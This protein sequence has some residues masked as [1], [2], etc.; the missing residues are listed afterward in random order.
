MIVY[1]TLTTDTFVNNLL[2]GDEWCYVEYGFDT[3]PD[4]FTRVDLATEGDVLAKNSLRIDDISQE[5]NDQQSITIRLG[6]SGDSK[7]DICVFDNLELWGDE[8][9]VFKK[10]IITH[11]VIIFTILI[12]AVFR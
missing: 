6:N 2:D 3:E 8:G 7:Y 9:G 11:N 5:Y 12:F 10:R 1:L 4:D